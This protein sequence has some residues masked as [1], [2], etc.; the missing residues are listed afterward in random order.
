MIDVNSL[1]ARA[2]RYLSL[3]TE[4]YPT[5]TR[6]RLMVVN[7]M[8]YLIVLAAINY[9]VIYASFGPVK[10]APLIAIN[11]F[12]V[13]FALAVPFLHRIGENLGAYFIVFFEFASL[14]VFTAFLGTESGI[15]INYII[16]AAVPFLALDRSSRKISIF[17]I[18]VVGFLLH[19]AARFL[20]PQT[21]MMIPQDSLLLANIYFLSAVTTFGLISAIV[22]FAL[23]NKD[24]AEARTNELLRNILPETIADRLMNE[25][26][27][28]IAESYP[29]V[30]VMFADTVGFTSLATKLGA[31]RTVALLSDV[32]TAFDK[33]A[34]AYD[35]EKIKT[36]GDAYMVVS[37]APKPVA[38]HQARIASLALRL[39]EVIPAIAKDHGVQLELRI[40]IASG[41]IIG[42]VIGRRKLVFDIWGDT[43]NLAARLESHGVAGRIQMSSH[44][45]EHLSERFI[46]E[47]RDEIDLKGF[48]LVSTSFLVAER[49]S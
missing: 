44:L 39:R 3:G 43:V 1:K 8:A 6:R 12:H 26:S 28:N 2:E 40:G 37:G 17:A 48:G 29:N 38:D 16:A 32:F 18:I 33:L 49:R 36:V 7:F 31:E 27:A 19:M 24:R 11:I 34:E 42:G 15:Q 41:P 22:Y 46:V 20:G 30:T 25:P 23:L 13:F 14:F 45:A 9:A 10:Y 4:G 5:E 47:S 35:V 21:G